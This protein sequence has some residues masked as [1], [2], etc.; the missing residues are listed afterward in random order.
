MNAITLH[1]RLYSIHFETVS[2]SPGNNM[3]DRRN[4]EHINF[5]IVCSKYA[6]ML[7]HLWLVMSVKNIVVV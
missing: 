6:L 1:G 3:L 5:R 7:F 4:C 2:Y